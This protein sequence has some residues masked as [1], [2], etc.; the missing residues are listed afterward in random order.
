MIAVTVSGRDEV[1]PYRVGLEMLR[2]IYRRHKGEF[3]WRINSI[4]RL[5]GSTRVRDAVE[6]DGIDAL[7]PEFERESREFQERS[8]PYFIYPPR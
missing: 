6:L 8:S 5:T 4:N 7:I 2:A 3:Q 1:Q